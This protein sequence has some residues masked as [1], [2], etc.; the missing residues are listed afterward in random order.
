MIKKK[1][2]TASDTA[3]NKKQT[4]KYTKRFQFLKNRKNYSTWIHGE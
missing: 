3:L 2:K 4:G 1:L